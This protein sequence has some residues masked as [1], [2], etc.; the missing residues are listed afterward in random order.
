MRHLIVV[1]AVV[2]SLAWTPAAAAEDVPADSWTGGDKALHFSAGFGLGVGGYAIGAA[3]LDER[4]VGVAFG[5]MLA[6]A[7]GGAK[8]G[9]DAAGLGEPSVKDFTWTVLGGLLGSGVSVTFDA[10][11]R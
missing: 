1:A 8:E 3:G 5:V 11:L 7:L 9:L 10:A 4:L 6:A 2:T